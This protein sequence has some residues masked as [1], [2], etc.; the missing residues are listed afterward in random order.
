MPDH[1]TPLSFPRALAFVAITLPVS[2]TGLRVLA[3]VS[4][5]VPVRLMKR[6][7]LFI[8]REAG[9]RHGREPRRDAGAAARYLREYMLAIL[10]GFPSLY[11]LATEG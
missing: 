2:S 8:L 5:A 3:V 10:M 6:D 11:H 4:A 7:L 1:N 9:K